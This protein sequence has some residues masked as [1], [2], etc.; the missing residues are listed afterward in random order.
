M[1]LER[2]CVAGFRTFAEPVEFIPDARFTVIHAPNGTGKSTLLDALYYGLLERHSVTGDGAERRFKSLGRDLTPTIEVD[3]AV[4]GQHFRLRKVFLSNGKS[5][6]LARRESG[7][8]IA[9]KDGSSADDFVREMFSATPPGKGVLEPNKHF[10]FHHVLFAPA[11]ARF[12]AL[13][14]SV[15]DHIRTLLGGAALAVTDGERTVEALALKRFQYFFKSD[16]NLKSAVDSA[17]VPASEERV[18]VARDAQ[19]KARQQ[20][21]LL[22]QLRLDYGDLEAEAGRMNAARA[23]LRAEIETMKA[24][25]DAYNRSLHALQTATRAEVEA[26]RP[27]EEINSA[28]RQLSVL[29]AERAAL[30]EA[31]AICAN[32]IRRLSQAAVVSIER[33]NE[34]RNAVENAGAVCAIV[35]ERG[36][37]VTAAEAYLAALAAVARLDIALCDYDVAAATR[38]E[39][40]VARS[41]IAAPEREE[42]A[43]LRTSAAEFDALQR[44]IAASALSLQVDAQSALTLEVVTGDRVGPVTVLPGQ[45]LTIAA[46]DASVV[47]DI[48]GVGRIRARGTDGAARARKSLSRVSA[49]LE[50]AYERFNTRSMTELACRSE[51]AEELQRSDRHAQDALQKALGGRTLSELQARR[52]AARAGVDAFEATYPA[53]RL[54]R[55]DA[56]ALRAAFDLDLERATDAANQARIELRAGEKPKVEVEQKLGTCNIL[57]TELSVKIETHAI[58]L[59]R[60]EADGLDD[61]T[62]L[63]RE[64]DLALVWNAACAAKENAVTLCARFVNDPRIALDRAQ[65]AEQDAGALYECAL[66]AARACRAQLDMQVTLGGYAQLVAT[67]ESVV[68][69]EAELASAHAQASAVACLYA[70]FEQVRNG[71]L[72]AIVEPITH[73]STRYLTR[74]TGSPIG[75]IDIGSGLTP[76]GLIQAASGEKISID[77]ML[78]TGEQ[79]Q[80]YFATRLALADVIASGRG[81]Q[82]FVVDDAL[83]ATDPNRLRRFIGILEDLSRERLQIIVTTADRSRYLGIKGA[84]H[85]DLAATLAARSAA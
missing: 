85:F 23:G 82:L 4:G 80:V 35:Q 43:A 77:G 45:M 1:I 54:H 30:V 61:G 32:E 46:T 29:R 83:T 10:G 79:E 55:P 5:A 8:Y 12:A 51:R 56:V 31:Q 73:A 28:I 44:T 49:L 81:R 74:I 22:E 41:S 53:W 34:A 36:P 11:R 26:R 69:A 42:L 39:I 40:S 52:N 19:A 67:E 24:E 3:F 37:V 16:R 72:A 70:A 64:R 58:Q 75:Q 78:S 71:R 38:A 25:V 47:I 50:S 84:R 17:N 21:A 65:V 18:R 76:E 27:Y 2:L 48:P 14:Q 57:A 63:R 68:A 15:G 66:G 59:A 13:P 62:R 33:Y 6:T 7:R 9:F 20:Y 60:I